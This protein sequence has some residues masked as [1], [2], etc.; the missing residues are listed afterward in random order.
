MKTSF[1]IVVP[2]ALVLGFAAGPSLAQ[3]FGPPEMREVWTESSKGQV[4]MNAFGECWHS[5]FGPPPPPGV[6]GIPV[7]QA[8][9]PVAPR[10]VVVAPP[11]PMPPRPVVSAA[12][13]PP[14]APAPAPYVA[15]AAPKRDRN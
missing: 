6:C 14:P 7:A 13:P 9:I 2:C 15:P 11:A 8:V 5:A 3:N 1:R 4:W 10:P 12:P